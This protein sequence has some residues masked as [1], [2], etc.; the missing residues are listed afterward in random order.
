MRLS[1]RRTRTLEEDVDLIDRL[2]EAGDDRTQ[3]AYVRL[4]LRNAAQ[5]IDRL[6]CDLLD[7]RAKN[8]REE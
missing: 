5:R 3:D 6:S 8:W 4:L 2:R 7:E 1:L